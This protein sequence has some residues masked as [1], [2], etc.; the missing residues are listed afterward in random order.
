MARERQR[1]VCEGLAVPMRA[2]GVPQEILT[3]NGKVFTGRFNQP[4]VEV[5]FDRICRENENRASADPASVADHDR[6]DRAVASQLA[7]GVPDRRVFPDLRAAQ[8]EL[9]DGVQDH[10]NER[11]HQACG[12]QPP[13]MRFGQLPEGATAS[14]AGVELSALAQDRTGQGWVPRRVASNGVISVSGQQISIGVQRSGARVDVN[15]RAGLLLVWP[16]AET[17]QDRETHQSEMPASGGPCRARP[18]VS[19]HRPT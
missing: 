14:P 5:L 17:P 4:L 7:C 9:N 16:G 10:T 18:T 15:V 11:P 19:P 1:Q 2:Y 6:E 12:R 13:G 8:R 3:D